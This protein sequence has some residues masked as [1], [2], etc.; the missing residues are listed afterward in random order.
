MG[1]PVSDGPAAHRSDWTARVTAAR[2]GAEVLA[3]GAA[4]LYFGYQFLDGWRRT[5]L[6]VTL[7]TQRA[8]AVG[9]PDRVAAS[10]HLAILADLV[11]GAN[12]SVRFGLAQA[13]VTCPTHPAAA[14]IVVDLVDGRRVA[15]EGDTVRWGRYADRDYHIAAG[16]RL[17]LAGLVTVPRAAA[18]VVEVV[19]S[20]PDDFP[21]SSPYAHQWQATTVSLP[22]EEGADTAPPVVPADGGRVRRRGS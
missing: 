13:R 12:G 3:I 17:Q 18:C 14:P 2:H 20:A 15:Y 22:R 4:A 5:N 21:G 6:D 11:K 8:P 9:A 19:V 7:R 1:R 16:E 10:D